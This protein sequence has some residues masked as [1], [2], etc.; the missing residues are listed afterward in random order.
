MIKKIL[1]MVLFIAPLGLAAQK[2]ATFDYATVMQ[3]MPETKK[4]QTELESLNNQ[5]RTEL[6]NMQKEI[7]TKM[8]KYEAEINDKTPENIRTRRAQ[9][10]QEMQQRLQQAYEDNTKNFRMKRPRKCNP[11]SRRLLML[12]MLFQ[13]KATT[14]I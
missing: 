3:A 8:E 7:Q 9:E 11:S 5:Y 13:K 2:F 14:S 6:Q 1:L 12:S 4:A 10:I